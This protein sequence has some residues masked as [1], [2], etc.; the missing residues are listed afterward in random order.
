MS[1]IGNNIC[2]LFCDTIK[3]PNGNGSLSW[4]T[5]W[6][7]YKPFSVNHKSLFNYLNNTNLGLSADT[8][9]GVAYL[10]KGFIVITNPTIVSNFNLL[11]ASTTTISFNSYVTKVSYDVTCV[12]NRGEFQLSNNP[13]FVNG[14]TPRVS[15]IALYDSSGN[16]IAIAK[17]DEHVELSGPSFAAF[18]ISIVL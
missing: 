12:V 8:A 11:S 9:V 6:N 13:T 14:D 10:D 3:K 15:E 16:L 17:T 7:T 4:S 1:V 5:G 2:F 18:S